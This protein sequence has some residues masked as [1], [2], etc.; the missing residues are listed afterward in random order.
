LNPISPQDNDSA[1]SKENPRFSIAVR[2][3]VEHVLRSGDLRS[4]FMGAA[5]AEEGLRAHQRLQRQ[6]PEG[7]EAEHAVRLEVVQPD[8]TL[9]IGGRIDGVLRGDDGVMVE[10]IKSTLRPLAE[11]E[12]ESSRVHWGQAQCYAYM[13]ARQEQLDQ[14]AV[15]LTYVHLESGKTLSLV[16]Q[17]SL[18]ALT[19]FF[20]DLLG[21]YLQWLRRLA[22]WITVRNQ[23]LAALPFPFDGYRPGQREMAVEVFRA[24]R[25]GRQ[26]L[27]QAATGIGKTMAALYPALKALGQ[28][29]VPKVVFLTARTTGRLAAEAALHA[30]A[31]KG[32]RLKWVTVTAKEK[33][34]FNAEPACSPELCP[35]ARG[36]YD[37]LNPAL[38]A[39]FAQDAFDREAIE[40]TARTHQVCPFEFALELVLWADGVIGDYNYAFDPTATLKRLFGDE[41]GGHAL[42]VDEAHNLADRAREMF[43]AELRKAP[44]LALR[45][46][47]KEPLPSLYRALG[48]VHSAMNALG[49][50]CREAEAGVWIDKRAPED[51]VARLQTFLGTAERWLR[52]NQ[53]APFRQ[54]LLRFYFDGLRFVRT[55]EQYSPVYATIAQGKGKE[56]EV[57]LFCM[58]PSEPLRECW[59]RC[60]AAVLFSATLTPADYFQTILGCQTDMGRLDLASPFPTENLAVFAAS[61]ISTF[62]RDRETSCAAV[63]HTIGNLVNQR[64]GHYLLF[65]PS[66]DYLAMIHRRFSD[67]CPRIETLVQKPEMA[68]GERDAFLARF[69]EPVRQ[70]LVGFAVMG[71]I[72]GEGIDLKG[73]RLTGVVI[74]G[75]G[76]PGIGP[77]RELLRAYYTQAHGCGFEF[78]YQYPGI[79]RVLQ[80]AGRLIRSETDRGVVL[81]IDRRYAQQRYRSL[82]PATWRLQ[83]LT[84]DAAFQR[85]IA[86]FWV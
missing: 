20:D 51:L 11:V 45:R 76:L 67:D 34:C 54:E 32:M 66:Y 42:L 77:E 16:R 85:R 48:R 24:I 82:L 78:A 55:A 1:P 5:R 80:A 6:R 14:V 28:G 13:L 46:A 69:G 39:I 81:L 64:R 47:L 71:G 74:V 26:L 60:R 19:E 8:F 10:E 84:N 29:M 22:L 52:R 61:H 50:Q 31:Q 36:H 57:K 62:Y 65:F 75:V 72:F 59:R 40:R 21:L 79:N 27:V 12:V 73:E 15:Q 9:C 86:D 43:S 41:A 18:A 56:I 23:S 68:E 30:L 7:Y 2:A 3:L 83:P 33:I 37:R 63:S 17:Q 25:D 58:D 53:P 49:R 4:D 38:E 44:V 70:T 35:Y